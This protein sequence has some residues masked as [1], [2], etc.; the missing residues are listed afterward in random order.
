MKTIEATTPQAVIERLGITLESSSPLGGVDGDWP[1]IGYQCRIAR[2]GRE[3]W[4]GPYKLG[5]GHVQIVDPYKTRTSAL[6]SVDEKNMLSAMARRPGAQFRDK[7][8]QAFACAKLAFVQKVTPKLP[9]V[10]HSLLMDGAA[11]DQTFEDWCAELGYSDD[12][13]KARDTFEQCERIGK[14]LARAF[15][16]A[17]LDELREAF[18]GY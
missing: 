11:I 10:L 18:Q 8:L 13:I 9:D 16:R 3:V 6:L 15:T 14:S 2:N 7:K 17:E 1:H 12:S 4:S 5:I